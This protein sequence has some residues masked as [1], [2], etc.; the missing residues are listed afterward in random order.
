LAPFVEVV[1]VCEPHEVDPAATV[2]KGI[3]LEVVV[4]GDVSPELFTALP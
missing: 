1:N 2:P 3:V 4:T